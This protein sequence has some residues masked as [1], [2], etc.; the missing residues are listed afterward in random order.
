[1]AKTIKKAPKK[2]ANK[3]LTKVEEKR[4]VIL[5]DAV[6]Q[7]KAE[8]YVATSGTYVDDKLDGKITALD[9]YLGSVEDRNTE[10]VEL[11]DYLDKMVSVKAPC[12]VCAKGSILL[13]S[14]R[15][16]N[17][18]S[19]S[20]AASCEL[21]DIADQKAQDMFGQ[22]NADMMEDFFEANSMNGL[23]DDQPED[24]G[25][26]TEY[27]RLIY[28]WAN[29]YRNSSDRLIA[30]FQNAIRNRGQFEPEQLK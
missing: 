24:K 11:K 7:I 26:D 2:K 21:S 17:N 20:E 9:E 30:I 1:M 27:E 14:I 12:E 15:K 3:P 16:Y 19:V 22:Q 6:A 29:R 8:K 5:K 13:S 4:V 18:L 28:K 25:G 10:E 23:D